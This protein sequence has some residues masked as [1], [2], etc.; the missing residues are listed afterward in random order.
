MISLSPQLV[1][2]AT[3]FVQ[4]FPPPAINWKRGD[5]IIT[6]NGSFHISHFASADEKTTSTLRVSKLDR[7]NREH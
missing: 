2:H 5:E 6:N 7:L 1:F 4:A 3:C